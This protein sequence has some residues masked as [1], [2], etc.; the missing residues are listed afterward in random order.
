MCVQLGVNWLEWKDQCMYVC[1]C[2]CG[3]EREREDS[4]EMC[5]S[6]ID[7]FYDECSMP[8]MITYNALTTVD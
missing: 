6:M 4:C 8:M 7:R 1:V 3:C 5:L 2:V